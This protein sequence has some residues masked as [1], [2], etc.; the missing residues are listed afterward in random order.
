MNIYLNSCSTLSSKKSMHHRYVQHVPSLVSNNFMD[1]HQNSSN[2]P[3]VSSAG[4]KMA[5]IHG[6]ALLCSDSAVDV[7][8]H[9]CLCVDVLGAHFVQQ[10]Q[11]T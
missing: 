2:L 6:A 11:R 1:K 5:D 3:A 10:Y 4:R 7:R 9:L 8:H